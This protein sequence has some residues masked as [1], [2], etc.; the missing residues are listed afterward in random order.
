MLNQFYTESELLQPTSLIPGYRHLTRSQ[1]IEQAG[2][3]V[4]QNTALNNRKRELR[5]SFAAVISEARQRGQNL[6]DF[7]DYADDETAELLL[8]FSV[9][10]YDMASRLSRIL[11]RELSLLEDKQPVHHRVSQDQIAAAN[12]IN[13]ADVLAERGWRINRGRLDCPFCDGG[14][15]GSGVVLSSGRYYCHRCQSSHNA[16]TLVRALDG[17]GFLDAVKSLTA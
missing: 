7:A 15:G 16:I 14:S 9:R 1:I 17:V 5:E 10:A 8:I 11:R 6:A 12:T 3:G 13:C 4:D 2:A